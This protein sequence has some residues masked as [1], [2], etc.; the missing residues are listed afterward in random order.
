MPDRPALPDEKS[1]PSQLGQQAPHALLLRIFGFWAVWFVVARLIFLGYEWQ[2]TRTLD[3]TLLTGL[4]L[5]GMR[6]DLSAAA[7]LTVVPWIAIVWRSVRR[8]DQ[9][10]QFLT[11]Y[12]ALAILATSLITVADLQLFVEWRYRLDATLI[13]FLRT[14]DEALA[15]SASAPWL[16]LGT[17]LVLL[18]ATSW[19][20]ARLIIARPLAD[21]RP[22]DASLR[23]PAAWRPLLLGAA[24]L[25]PLRG[26][27]QGAA[28]SPRYAAFSSND[29]ANQAALNATWHFAHAALRDAQQPIDNPY[30]EMPAA[31]A[32]RL[33]DSLLAPIAG[34]PNGRSPLLR[35]A[36][37]NVILI[38][39]ESLTAKLVGR[40]GGVP[41]VTPQLDRL[42]REGILFDSL[43]ASAGRT[44]QALVAVLGSFPAQPHQQVLD[45]P[46]VVASLPVLSR[47][48]EQGGYHSAFYYGGDL[49]FSNFRTL[50]THAGFARVVDQDSFAPDERRSKWG[51][52]DGI[53]LQRTL[54]DLA[55][56]P[57]PFFTHVLTLSSHEP[58]DVPE[59]PAFAGTGD[60]TLFMNAHHYSDASVGAFIDAA[61]RQPWWDSTL[62][63]IVADHGSPRPVPDPIVNERIPDRYRIP[64]LWLGGALAVRDTVIHTVASQ[65]D[66]APTLLTLVGEP[67]EARDFRWGKNLLARRDG[68]FAYFPY[69][70]GFAYIDA[71]GWVVYDELADRIVQAGGAGGAHHQRMGTA[72]LQAA[73][74]DFLARRGPPDPARWVALRVPSPFA[75]LAPI[76][77]AR[78]ARTASP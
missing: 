21:A 66:L 77:D 31:E 49:E 41:G 74:D 35:I 5:R 42:S 2:L 36:R 62:V 64:M 68:G 9:C 23:V 59:A 26:G 37:P 52:P 51:V 27:V 32:Q 50:T 48:L 1:P 54:T 15:S 67:S 38:T 25:I 71:A 73:Y 29:F 33:T 16:P 17:I 43:F 44:A 11:G 57:R 60:D 75:P 65:L 61:R 34:A 45:L 6:L 55:R 19:V 3:A 72:L 28:L 40:L 47:A 63:I 30:R 18:I 46:Q 76:H 53:V 12:L 69:H 8:A 14:P 13:H 20:A 70:D 78:E 39:W 10:Q 24:L 58:F 22:G 7:W 56:A 4:W